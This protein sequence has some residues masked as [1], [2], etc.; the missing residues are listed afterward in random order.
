MTAR[1]VGRL[2]E[3]E[4]VVQ[5][6]L[7]Y[8]F[9]IEKFVW[10]RLAFVAN[11]AVVGGRAQRCMYPSMPPECCF[12]C[13]ASLLSREGF[14]LVSDLGRCGADVGPA[15][16]GAGACH[17]PRNPEHSPALGARSV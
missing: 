14:A 13:A 1:V 10:L 3:L 8:V 4:E 6:E 7:D 9:R 5:Q 12:S 11:G 2:E 17:R 16:R 15:A